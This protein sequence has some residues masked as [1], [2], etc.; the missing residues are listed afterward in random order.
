MSKLFSE[1]PACAFVQAFNS[2]YN[3]VFGTDLAADIIDSQQ[4]R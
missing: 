1:D 2:G 4:H 3:H